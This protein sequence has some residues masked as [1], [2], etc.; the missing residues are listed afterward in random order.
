MKKRVARLIAA[1][2]LIG[3][4]GAIGVASSASAGNTSYFVTC[5]RGTH[6]T[7]CTLWKVSPTVGIKSL[8]PVSIRKVNSTFPVT[9]PSLPPLPSPGAFPTP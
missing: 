6:Y 3:T 1:G 2:A 8:G 4:L 5:I 9:V 7:G